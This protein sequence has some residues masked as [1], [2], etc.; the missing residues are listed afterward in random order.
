MLVVYIY[1]HA[2]IALLIDGFFIIHTSLGIRRTESSDGSRPALRIS[3]F[4]RGMGR[5][6]GIRRRTRSGRLRQTRAQP[7]PACRA[8]GHGVLHRDPVS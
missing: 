8:A 2:D 6:S 3:A 5:G 7:G 4:S 1:K